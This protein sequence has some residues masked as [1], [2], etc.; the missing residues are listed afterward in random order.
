MSV[1]CGVLVFQHYFGISRSVSN[2]V[3]ALLK[4]WVLFCHNIVEGGLGGW[5]EWRAISQGVAILNLEP[6]STEK[7]KYDSA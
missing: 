4:S 6:V 7:R 2:P 1:G 3:K 5:G